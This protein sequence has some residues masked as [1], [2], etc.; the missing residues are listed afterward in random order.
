MPRPIVIGPVK[1]IFD[2]QITYRRKSPTQKQTP[3]RSLCEE[4]KKEELISRR[5]GYP[6][7]LRIWH[8]T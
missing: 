5:S 8:H 4:A 7:I 2:K 6:E 1:L 3:L